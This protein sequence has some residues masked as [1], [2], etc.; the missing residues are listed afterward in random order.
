MRDQ[1]D[2]AGRQRRHA[3]VHRFQQEA[4]RV[5]YVAGDVKRKNLALA[6]LQHLVSEDHPFEEQVAVG[7]LLALPDNVLISPEFESA[8]AR[9]LQQVLFLGRKRKE[10]LQL[11]DE[12]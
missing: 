11:A 2:R 9:A 5:I 4:L 12:W 8:R 7:R 6:V 10:L 3:V 1:G